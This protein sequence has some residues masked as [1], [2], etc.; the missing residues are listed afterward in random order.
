PPIWTLFEQGYLDRA[1]IPREVFNQVIY[2]NDLSEKYVDMGIRLDKTIDVSTYWFYF[3]MRDPLFKNNKNLRHAMSLCLDRDEMIE[4][5]YNNRGKAAQSILPP[6]LEG[7]NENFVNPWSS[8]NPQKAKELLTKAGYPNGMDPKTGRPLKIELIL[9][10]SQGA[11]SKYRFYIDQFAQCG[12]DLQIMTLDWP[13]VL[14]RKFKKNFQMIHGGWHADYP[15]PQNFL[16][17][18]YGPNSSS[19]YNENSYFNPEF[20]VLYAKMKNM[21]SGPERRKIIAR[22]NA[23]VADD[24]PVLFLF[25]PVSFGLS[26]QW[27]APIRPHPINTN[28]LKYRFVDSGL[29]EKKTEEWNR[30][31]LLAYSVPAVFFGAAVFLVFLTIRGY[32]RME[33]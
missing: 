15:D 6:G 26:H 22:M 2:R 19:S 3:N 14:E 12:L 7:Y 23:I 20:D 9:V 30:P 28:Q 4:R 16:Q 29:R 27:F 5:F 11:T 13:T 32:R 8:F 21:K 17:L 24:A 33:L 18:L 31:G 25:H 1:G 10:A